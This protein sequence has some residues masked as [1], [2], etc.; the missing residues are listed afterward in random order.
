M[1]S[2]TVYLFSLTLLDGTRCN[3][4]KNVPTYNTRASCLFNE[5][6]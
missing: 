3:G 5:I 4:K 2:F 6:L 1:F